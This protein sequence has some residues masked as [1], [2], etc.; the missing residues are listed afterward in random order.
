MVGPA[1]MEEKAASVAAAVSYWTK[2]VS[3][4][5]I[6]YDSVNKETFHKTWSIEDDTKVDYK[7]KLQLGIY[8]KGVAA[9]TGLL[10]RGQYNG[11]YLICI[12][13]DSLE[14]FRTWCGN[15]Y[16]LDTLA[17]WTRVDWHKNPEKIHVFF[18]SKTPLKDLA[19]SKDNQIIE[20]YGMNPHL[21][22]VYGKHKDG[23][24]IGPYDTE[25]IAIIDEVKK[26][27]IESRIKRVIPTYLDEDSDSKYIEELEKPE[28]IIPAGSVHHAVRT[29]LMSV[30][31]RWKN[32]F[33]EMSD[34]QRFQYV[35]DWDKKKAELSD[36]PAYIN[37]NPKKLE[38]L[39][40]GIKRKYQGQRQEGRGSQSQTDVGWR[41][42]AWMYRISDQP[43][44]M[45]CRNT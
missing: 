20:V 33:A 29:M 39:W 15:D 5:I 6:E 24:P 2:V 4:H 23:N 18:L 37:A 3:T 40:E 45:H 36:R 28:T 32:G 9:R 11:W 8:N 27:E 14:A 19:R 43:K 7:A 26:L 30:Y 22:C 44:S 21:V 17:K 42:D 12:D 25:E 35:V 41:S 31:F 16:D 38:D 1:M 10:H 13:F 34:D